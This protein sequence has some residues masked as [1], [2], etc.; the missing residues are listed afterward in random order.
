M[1]RY[2]ELRPVPQLASLR[3]V[4]QASDKQ[5]RMNPRGEPKTMS[6]RFGYEVPGSL[7]IDAASSHSVTVGTFAEAPVR[8]VRGRGRTARDA[9]ASNQVVDTERWDRH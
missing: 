4:Q 9:E 1:T 8:M 2:A 5:G 7:S 6:N 3:A